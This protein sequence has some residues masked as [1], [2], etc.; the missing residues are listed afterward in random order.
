MSP[1]HQK[2]NYKKN[3]CTLLTP[4]GKKTKMYKDD[5]G[6]VIKQKKIQKNLNI[7][8]FHKQL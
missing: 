7:T 8:F 6:L 2:T 4:Y 5:E 1:T 3:L